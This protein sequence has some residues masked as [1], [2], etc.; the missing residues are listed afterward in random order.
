M[1]GAGHCQGILHR[2]SSHWYFSP[3]LL[4]LKPGSAC[5][6]ASK[7][8]S[9]SFSSVLGMVGTGSKAGPVYVRQ[10]GKVKE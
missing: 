4:Q 2:K 10:G 9:A 5:C 3:S 1:D 6:E 8:T 7:M